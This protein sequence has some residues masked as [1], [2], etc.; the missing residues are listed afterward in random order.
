MGMVASLSR[1]LHLVANMK[2]KWMV[3][4]DDLLLTQKLNIFIN[5]DIEIITKVEVILTGAIK[6]IHV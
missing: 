2:F 3:S 1:N 5:R 6:I 4:R